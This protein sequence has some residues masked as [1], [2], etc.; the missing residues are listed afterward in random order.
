MFNV[1]ERGPMERATAS[2]EGTGEMDEALETCIRE[3]VRRARAASNR[4]AYDREEQALLELMEPLGRRLIATARTFQSLDLEARKSFFH[5]FLL[6][7]WRQWVSQ[8]A[9]YEPDAEGLEGTV[10][11][12]NGLDARIFDGSSA[13]SHRE[14]ARRRACLRNLPLPSLGGMVKNVPAA[15]LTLL[16]NNRRLNPQWRILL[17]GIKEPRVGG[18][19]PSKGGFAA[20]ISCRFRWK[21]RD[22]A[23][24]ENGAAGASLLSSMIF[25]LD[26]SES[27]SGAAQSLFPDRLACVHSRLEMERTEARLELEGILSRLSNDQRAFLNPLLTEE[28]VTLKDLAAVW[29][30]SP[31]AVIKRLK[32]IRAGLPPHG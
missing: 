1:I 18:F 13:S 19:D 30:I 8:A 11:Y 27:E 23:R 16:A 6:E 24:A 32:K 17:A 9:A 22:H 12:L 29:G 25:S 26:A 3:L 7:A 10:D 20:Y 14:K 2:T 4:E 31:A 15:R 21:I 5:G 28:A